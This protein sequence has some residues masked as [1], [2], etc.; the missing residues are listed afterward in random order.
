MPIEPRSRYQSWEQGSNISKGVGFI[1]LEELKANLQ[2]FY[3]NISG[4]GLRAALYAGAEVFRAEIEARTPVGRTYT[5]TTKGGKTYTVRDPHPGQAK[6]SV[7]IYQR[8]S[9]TRLSVA[10]EEIALLVGYEKKHA[11][12]MYWYE[13]GT[14]K[15]SAKPFMRSA[16]DT[17][18]ERAMETAVNALIPFVKAAA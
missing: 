16:Y 18:Q 3:T 9:R 2:K 6:G 8:Q 4:P 5:Y 15:Q 14:S 13:Y 1:G 11:Y 17:A 7:I 12:W 10:A